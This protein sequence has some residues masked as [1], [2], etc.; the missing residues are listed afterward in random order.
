[1]V[2]GVRLSCTAREAQQ[3][4]DEIGA[5]LPTPRLLDL[6]HEQAAIK[7][8]PQPKYYPGGRGMATDQAVRDHSQ[9]INRAS[10]GYPGVLSP[11]GKHW[12]LHERATTTRAVLYGWPVPWT[13]GRRSWRGIP[14]YPSVTDPDV[15]VIQQP[16]PAH[17]YLHHD[18]SMT[19]ILVHG[20]C[21]VDGQRMR[22]A[23]VL[24]D[25]ELC[26]LL[27]APGRPL[28]SPRLPGVAEPPEPAGGVSGAARAAVNRALCATRETDDD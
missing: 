14:T 20:V 7:I 12:V 8:A 27:V 3:C 1:M 11:V 24:C 9:R 16:S 25:P 26:G 5:V 28:R 22:T 10:R 2:G 15:R 19:L 6:R 4:A 21:E 23:D 18:Y 17:D 13:N